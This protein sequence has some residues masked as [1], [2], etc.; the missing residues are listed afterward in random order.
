M[1]CARVCSE[2]LPGI[3]TMLWHKRQR[4][5]ARFWFFAVSPLSLAGTYEIPHIRAID[6]AV[7][8]IIG[9]QV[10]Q[11]E[12]GCSQNKLVYWSPLEPFPSLGIGHF[13]WFPPGYQGPFTQTFPNLLRHLQKH[14]AILPQWLIKACDDGCPWSTRE[15]LQ[16]ELN[17]DKVQELRALLN[18]TI[19]LQTL[20]IIEQLRQS[21]T[22]IIATAR[23]PDQTT[24]TTM[25]NEL[26]STPEGLYTLVDYLNFKGSGTNPKERYN[27][28]GWGVLQV[29]EYLIATKQSATPA[30]FA[31][32]AQY[33]LRQRV[34][35]AP[36]ESPDSQ[37]L[38]GWLNRL[39]TYTIPLKK[40][41]LK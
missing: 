17:S 2:L 33:L 7:A 4:C 39:K 6:P 21:L 12:S 3:P 9:Y 32:A 11:N 13:I 8:Q 5:T 35:N 29:F 20:F 18:S 40:L 31:N 36:S 27:G 15:Q 41:C 14:G 34:A 19:E 38:A 1:P 23:V 10:W 30:T 24:I 28:Y 26:V 22:H 16:K 37:R 25:V